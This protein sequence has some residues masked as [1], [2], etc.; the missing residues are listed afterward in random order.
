[1]NALLV[2]HHW[3]PFTHH[4]PSGGYQRLAY[5]MA[6]LCDVDV[7]MWHK[8]NV[9][10]PDDGDSPFPVH[11]VI[12]PSSDM[13]L[14]RRLMLSWHARRM[15]PSFNL[16]H[17]LYSVPS[18][19]PS[20]VCP[21]VATVHV[22]PGIK[23]G[24]W[25]KYH[26]VIQT[27]AFKRTSHIIVVS[28][29]LYDVLADRY[30]SKKVTYIPHGIDIHV[31]KSGRFDTA[32]LRHRLLRDRFRLLVLQVGAHGSDIQFL[33]QLAKRHQDILF[34]MINSARP[35][36]LSNERQYIPSDYPNIKWMRD[37]SE[38]D[39]ISI[40][41]AS[42]I[43]FRPLKFATANN[44]ILEAMAMSKPIVTHAI[45]G[46][47]DYLDDTTAFLAREN[48]D[49]MSQFQYAVEHP[50]E[51][52]EKGRRA[53]RRVEEEFAWEHV[54]QRTMKVYERVG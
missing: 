11:R 1:M 14:E 6:Q 54:A 49:L 46:V 13:F 10:M 39:M 26:G 45:P 32:A 2:T 22:L 28:T 4:S 24:L 12:T 38:K 20:R 29:N 34:L 52:E 50:D 16:V 36:R 25:T 15:A 30:G 9:A 5:Y 3:P 19:F 48:K 7:L 40:Y 35:H 43:F 17:A 44:S 37:V 27:M 47:T 42:D 21:T 18:L 31:F 51:R 53:R 41:D 33:M 8:R 23:P